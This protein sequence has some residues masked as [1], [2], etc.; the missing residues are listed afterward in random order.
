LTSVRT[1]VTVGLAICCIAAALGQLATGTL[2]ATSL[3]RLDTIDIRDGGRRLTAAPLTLRVGQHIELGEVIEHLRT[4]GYYDSTRSAPA[5]YLATPTAITV[6]PRFGEFAAATIHWSGT[7]VSSLRDVSGTMLDA[8]AIEPETLQAWDYGMDGVEHEILQL[9]APVTALRNRAILDAIVASEEGRFREQHGLDLLRLIRAAVNGSGASTIAMQ[10][11]RQTVLHDRRRTLS[12]K[13]AEIGLAMAIDRKYAKDDI[14]EAYLTRIYLGTIGGRELRGFGAAAKVLLDRDDLRR[15]TLTEAATLV[16]SLNRP[17]AYIAEVRA[18]N[19]V[20]LKAQRDRVLDLVGAR[21]RE[22]Y[23]AV[24]IEA[25]KAEPLSFAR[26]QSSGLRGLK[27]QYFID[28]AAQFVPSLQ[29]GRVYL[30]VDGRVQRAADAAVAAGLLRLDAR[31]GSTLDSPVQVALIAVDPV[32]GEVRAVVGGRSYDASQFNR[33]TMGG[34][35]VGS[36]I[37]PYDY[38]GAFE[39]GGDEGVSLSPDSIVLDQPTVFRF[40]NTPWSPR[41]YGGEYG[42]SITRRQALA[43]S[44]NVAAV[45]VSAWAGFQRIATL[46]EKATGQSIKTVYPSFALG[47]TEATPAQVAQAYTV[48]VNGGTVRPLRFVGQFAHVAGTERTTP[49]AIPIARAE[50]ARKVVE[51]LR[52]VFDLGTARRARQ[53]G[54]V[55]PAAGKTGTTDDQ[56]D[57]WFAGFSGDLLTVVWVGRDDNVALGLTGGE[58]AL[59]I[60]TEFMMSV[61]QQPIRADN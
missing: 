4:L 9:P 17:D 48:F 13:L 31:V 12:R 47:S 27:A 44:K 23:S 56:R 28:H 32:T 51:M 22:R 33:A 10:I 14:L 53:M 36:L 39:R 57:A 58:A 29:E 52:A 20:P 55:A 38:L 50:S 43:Q 5:T 26:V 25:A 60:W 16:A 34:R 59:P 46:W 61:T 37:K 8:V 6:H 54:F 49:P 18:G 1:G 30:T 40:A 3:R 11:A 19:F 35:Q 2:Y 42:G 41:N 7:T 15:L 45:K 21:F 24:S